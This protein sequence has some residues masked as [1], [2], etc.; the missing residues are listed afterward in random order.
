MKEM[1]IQKILVEISEGKTTID[2]AHRFP[3]IINDDDVYF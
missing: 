2:I 1:E 3:T